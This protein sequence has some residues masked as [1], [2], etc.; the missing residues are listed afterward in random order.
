[1]ILVQGTI[2]VN[3][4]M[5]MGLDHTQLAPYSMCPVHHFRDAEYTL[6][7]R[8]LCC[9]MADGVGQPRSRICM[10][11]RYCVGKGQPQ[12]AVFAL[13][14]TNGQ[15]MSIQTIRRCGGNSKR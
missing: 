1:M 7:A 5:T 13:E 15:R 2:S 12:N 9:G 6:A 4:C 10:H 8:H 14:D 3:A 11:A